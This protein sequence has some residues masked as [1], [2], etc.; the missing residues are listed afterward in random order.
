MTQDIASCGTVFSPRSTTLD[1][2]FILCLTCQFFTLLSCYFSAELK[3]HCCRDGPFC[4]GNVTCFCRYQVS[5]H[6][7]QSSKKPLFL[8]QISSLKSGF[9]ISP[10]E[11]F[12]QLQ[13]ASTVNPPPIPESMSPPVRDLLLR[14]L[15]CSREDR[16]PAKDLLKH[17]LFTMPLWPKR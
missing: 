3:R 2:H 4:C 1:N 9:F 14:C 11:N 7:I 17:P 15:E 12:S 6:N 8:L 10:E 13:I 5:L 16:P